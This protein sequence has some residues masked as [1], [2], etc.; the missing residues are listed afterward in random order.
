MLGGEIGG[1]ENSGDGGA[2][3]GSGGGREGGPTVVDGK[4]ESKT[5]KFSEKYEEIIREGLFWTVNRERNIDTENSGRVCL[6]TCCTVEGILPSSFEVMLRREGWESELSDREFD[7]VGGT[8]MSC[9]LYRLWV[10]IC[11]AFVTEAT[12]EI[13]EGTIR[14]FPPMLGLP[15]LKKG[16]AKMIF[17]PET[18]NISFGE[19]ERFP[20]EYVGKLPMIQIKIL[21]RGRVDEVYRVRGEMNHEKIDKI[22]MSKDH[23]RDKDREE[24]R[25]LRYQ[26]LE[27]FDPE[28][29][30]LREDLGE[31][32][33]PVS[34][35]GNEV[36]STSPV[37]GTALGGEVSPVI[38]TIVGKKYEAGGGGQKE[39]STP[40]L[41]T[42]LDHEC[43][44]ALGATAGNCREGAEISGTEN[45]ID[46]TRM[47]TA[48][49]MVVGEDPNP[50]LDNPMSAVANKRIPQKFWS[51]PWARR[52]ELVVLHSLL[53]HR[54]S[55]D[56]FGLGFSDE[57]KDFLLWFRK[58]RKCKSC[59]IWRQV[60]ILRQSTTIK[61]V[62]ILPGMILFVDLLYTKWRVFVHA[63]DGG[64]KADFLRVAR[65]YGRHSLADSV[66]K[67]IFKAQQTFGKVYFL[68]MFD[69]GMENRVRT[70]AAL[71]A[72]GLRNLPVGR[73]Q[74]H[75]IAELEQEHGPI[76]GFFS[77]SLDERSLEDI[78]S[79]EFNL[80]LVQAFIESRHATRTLRRWVNQPSYGDYQDMDNSMIDDLA[81]HLCW[82][83]RQI[84]RLGSPFSPAALLG[85]EDVMAN[86]NFKFGAMRA[87][88][89]EYL[90]AEQ[91]R[92]D[93]LEKEFLKKRIRRFYEA[94][95]N[96]FR[97]TRSPTKTKD[98]YVGRMVRVLTNL[99]A[100]GKANKPNHWT[101]LA[102]VEGFEKVTGDITVSFAHNPNVRFGISRTNIK[103]F[104]EEYSDF[105]DVD[106]ECIMNDGEHFA[107]DL[108]SES[109]KGPVKEME[110]I[111]GEIAGEPLLPEEERK[112]ITA[113]GAVK[114]TPGPEEI[115]PPSLF[116]TLGD[117]AFDNQGKL[118]KGGLTECQRRGLEWR[119]SL[120]MLYLNVC[121]VCEQCYQ[122]P[123]PF[124]G[125]RCEML[126]KQC[127]RGDDT[128][129]EKV[130]VR[131]RAWARIGTRALEY[132]FTAE[133]EEMKPY[134]RTPKESFYW[135]ADRMIA[136]HGNARE[137]YG[138]ESGE[139]FNLYLHTE[140]NQVFIGE[141]TGEREK[142]FATWEEGEEL[143]KGWLQEEK[144]GE[145]QTKSP[146]GGPDKNDKCKRHLKPLIQSGVVTAE[147]AR[148]LKKFPSDKVEL[149]EGKLKLGDLN[150]VEIGQ[151]AVMRGFDFSQI[152][153]IT[154]LV[155]T[156]KNEDTRKWSLEKGTDNPMIESFFYLLNGEKCSR[157][158]TQMSREGNYDVGIVP[159]E[160][161]V[162]L[163]EDVFRIPKGDNGRYLTVTWGERGA[164]TVTP[165]D[166]GEKVTPV[167]TYTARVRY[168]CPEEEREV[169]IQHL[170]K[171][172]MKT[173]QVEIPIG[174]LRDL[175]Q[176]N[177]LIPSVEEEVGEIVSNGIFGK[178]ASKKEV[179]GKE[180]MSSR[181]VITVKISHGVIRMV[182]KRIKTRWVGRGFEDQRNF[183]STRA[184]TLSEEGFSLLTILSLL[185]RIFPAFMD[186]A[187]AF[188]KALSYRQWCLNNDDTEI[189]LQVP[190]VIQTLTKF[191]GILSEEYVE[192]VKPLYGSG[193]APRGWQN[194]CF[195]LLLQLGFTQ[196]SVGPCLFVL[197]KS[198]VSGW[199]SVAEWME[200]RVT[201]DDRRKREHQPIS[202]GNIDGEGTELEEGT[203]I[204]EAR[205]EGPF[206]VAVLR[207]IIID[208]EKDTILND[209]ILHGSTRFP[210]E[211]HK[212][213]CTIV[214]VKVVFFYRKPVFASN[215][216]NRI[217]G[218]AKPTEERFEH[219][220]MEPDE[221]KE[222]VS[223]RMLKK[224]YLQSNRGQSTDE[225]GE[226]RHL[227]PYCEELLGATVGF[228]R[229]KGKL[230]GAVGIH[231][232]DMK[233]V[234]GAFFWSALKEF[235]RRYRVSSV[236]CL[237]AWRWDAF[238]GRRIMVIPEAVLKK[239]AQRMINEWRAGVEN[240]EILEAF[241]KTTSLMWGDEESQT[242]TEG[243][244][245][246]FQGYKDDRLIPCIPFEEFSVERI[247]EESRFPEEKMAILHSQ[248]DYLSKIRP[249]TLAAM[250]RYYSSRRN[251]KLTGNK[252][253]LS[254]LKSPHRKII[255][256]LNWVGKG[257]IIGKAT[258]SN[259]AKKVFEVDEADQVEEIEEHISDV[260]T[261]LEWM[262]EHDSCTRF[263]YECSIQNPKGEMW[264]KMSKQL[265]VGGVADA[266]LERLAYALAIYSKLRVG[267]LNTASFLTKGPK[268]KITSSTSSETL[269][270]VLLAVHGLLLNQMCMEV[271]G[272]KNP[273][274]VAVGT[275]SKN[276]SRVKVGGA[277]TDKNLEKDA[278]E[279]EKLE[280][281]GL[282]SRH[283][284]WGK[285]NP[286]DG[287]TKAQ[288][289]VDLVAMKL[290]A[291]ATYLPWDVIRMFW[292]ENAEAGARIVDEEIAARL[293]RDE[294]N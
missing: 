239:R 261:L 170:T 139:D 256:E 65:F 6:D 11:G 217:L 204:G 161:D 166:A 219:P 72:A 174:T 270:L 4:L 41:G 128:I 194:S 201:K 24:I 197:Y 109:A 249:C 67:T 137:R 82:R 132:E 58:D 34:E 59:D 236:G 69:I 76:R 111:R 97:Y 164:P 53:G 242:K 39:E 183:T 148:E 43:A 83:M 48:G 172:G 125:F 123:F 254:K 189:F 124:R 198:V 57:E 115:V 252:F 181:L 263:F 218:D 20:V 278:A 182:I 246:E 13:L 112:Q 281:T 276:A 81:E 27:D 215:C 292:G 44:S 86:H 2:G 214:P 32:L 147:F 56:R 286:V 121:E 113:E 282:L 162:F 25:R 165:R 136:Q 142:L 23:P 73:K 265:K 130:S 68:I 152:S 216:H 228:K 42:A 193:E 98:L 287:G 207:R 7:S 154:A 126:G 234:G 294:E 71:T 50:T 92:K 279:L 90:H 55:I 17:S 250:D 66:I 175:G 62:H 158:F 14:K 10:E 88:V 230:C 110:E 145:T 28:F 3:R 21:P 240:P 225:F 80:R 264:E 51:I 159:V 185:M 146:L 49:R 140:S 206:W 232:D 284:I 167:N 208:V 275:D 114:V 277:P 211:N 237:S 212:Y 127:L 209:V 151:R 141:G 16:K 213:W 255:G 87:G 220:E 196:S 184:F 273:R 134:E 235:I 63:H 5:T 288:K 179:Q 117:T 188:L 54:A 131:D 241:P 223:P 283:K 18:D 35:A 222:A 118:T 116:E 238:L 79:E 192:L 171:T 8:V 160:V 271:L 178:L 153:K 100:Y 248:E 289:N 149:V 119:M 253:M 61:Y 244:M 91:L 106:M 15:F 96:N 224:Y 200:L 210:A 221:D 40:V 45:L 269:V 227:S 120:P 262:K 169:L 260:N 247:L 199:E 122:I 173:M 280:G 157:K 74:W 231:V 251:L 33:P 180:K 190:A 135:T 259:L 93:V 285:S 150:E 105:R 36:E 108:F 229:Q 272:W 99:D 1:E 144:E 186:V 129:I 22:Y 293:R 233:A 245:T 176:L 29:R 37:L 94:G 205:P 266:S 290:F 95:V 187:V 258:I 89:P 77:S 156:A 31:E 155:R 268:R 75:G 102:K 85:Q 138:E 195:L 226:E 19:S 70:R 78:R 191:Q 52:V 143:A 168:E 163:G 103:I 257:S 101:W 38:G 107:P 177:M 12:F 60:Q 104:C 47:G 84:P 274:K 203:W 26:E 267:V 202:D 9:G 243:E 64:A 46:P 291:E 133:E 30:T